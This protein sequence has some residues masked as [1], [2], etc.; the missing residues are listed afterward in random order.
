MDDPIAE[1]L[2]AFPPMNPDQI[3]LLR[4]LVHRFE[5]PSGQDELRL[6][7]TDEV[8]ERLCCSRGTVFNLIRAGRLHAVRVTPGGG[9]RVKLADLR[10]FI[11]ALDSNDVEWPRGRG[12]R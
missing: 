7:R 8:A 9:W 3:A 11:A 10:D 5:G 2:Q 6:M 1:V 4:V 12:G